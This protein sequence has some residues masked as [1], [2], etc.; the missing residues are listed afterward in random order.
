M[1]DAEMW[2]AWENQEDN[3]FTVSQRTSTTEFLPKVNPKQMITLVSANVSGDWASVI[4]SRDQATSAGT[5][6]ISLETKSI[7]WG[8]GGVGLSDRPKK[9]FDSEFHVHVQKGM[10]I[11]DFPTTTVTLSLTSGKV[12]NTHQAAC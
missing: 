10:L 7:L 9:P 2:I 1:N 6:A 4:I 8:V 11:F 5:R 3:T 12:I